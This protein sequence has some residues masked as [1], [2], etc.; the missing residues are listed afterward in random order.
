MLWTLSRAVCLAAARSARSVLAANPLLAVLAAVA[1]AGMPVA[2]VLGGRRLASEFRTEVADVGFARGFALGLAA[3]A[4][5]AGVAAA[6]L[7]PAADATARQLEAA[8]VSRLRLVLAATVVPTAIGAAFLAVPALLFAATLAGAAG[9]ATALALPAVAALGAAG[10]EGVRLVGRTEPRGAAIVAAAGAVWLFAGLAA[11]HGLELGP[12][13]LLVPALQGRHQAAATC[14]LAAVAAIGTALWVAACSFRR[15]SRTRS[16]RTR[17]VLPV[18]RHAFA[19]VASVTAKRVGRHGGL[20]AHGAATVALPTAAAVGLRLGLGVG[21]VPLV[22]FCVALGMTAAAIV[23]SAALGLADDAR[24]LF[25]TSPQR[26]P[27]IKGGVALAGVACAATL[28]VA[29]AVA[30]AP[31]ARADLHA[32]LQLEGA[33]AFVLGCSA[34]AAALVPWR[35]DRVVQQLAAYGAIVGVV[36]AAWLVIGRLATV[37]PLSDDAFGLLAGNATLLAGAA[38]AAWGSR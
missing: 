35:P 31:V 27:V 37:A 21:G 26:R 36:I 9:P 13:G 24:W 15:P 29:D 32:Y 30:I 16:F 14:A 38:V 10:A 8:P 2:A 1:A 12:T 20:R 6:L 4:L 33:V 11:D 19:A 18:P 7:A 17:A 3:T 5:A 25:A 22:G 34:A 23:P 28:I